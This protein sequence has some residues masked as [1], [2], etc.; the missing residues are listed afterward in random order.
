MSTF[1]ASKVIGS[2]LAS[3]SIWIETQVQNRLENMKTNP[4]DSFENGLYCIKCFVSMLVSF[5]S[6]IYAL[7]ICWK[8][9]ASKGSS[10]LSFAYTNLADDAGWR[11]CESPNPWTT[12]PEFSKLPGFSIGMLQVDLLH[13]WHLGVGRDL[14][15]S[16]LRV[17][18]KAKFF[19]RG[20]NLAD[21]LAAASSSLR[22]YAKSRK[23]SLHIKRLTHANLTWRSDQYPETRCKGY[24]TYIMVAWLDYL[25]QH[26]GDGFASRPIPDDV[27]TVVWAANSL[28]GCWMSSDMFLQPEE[29]LHVQV[30]GT[31]FVRTYLKLAVQALSDQVRLWKIRPKFHL[32]HHLIISDSI[33]N[34]HFSATW[35]DEDAVK[36]TMKVKKR[37]HRLRATDHCIR[38]WLLGL[39]PKLEHV[40]VELEKRGTCAP[41]TFPKQNP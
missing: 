28:M 16:I 41:E 25:L 19:R 10:D 20:G 31:L 2:T 23:L 22:Q 14:T 9:L 11:T 36:R 26:H 40:L 17:L 35:M 18:A 4:K 24:D 8:C 27:K 21:Q 30:V 29:K 39:K 13:V 34:P 32:L 38:R 3:S 33:W 7:Q 12:P 6:L 37:T 1:V 5:I 15:A